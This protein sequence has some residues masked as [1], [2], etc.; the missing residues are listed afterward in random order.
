MKKVVYDS[1]SGICVSGELSASMVKLMGACSIEQLH[2][3]ISKDIPDDPKVERCEII[4]NHGCLEFITDNVQRYNGT[5]RGIRVVPE[6]ATFAGFEF[7][8][9]KVRANPWLWTS[10]NGEHTLD[11]SVSGSEWTPTHAKYVLFNIKT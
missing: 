1:D 7:A 3:T 11:Y 6:M 4:E 5:A 8:D 9:G 2:V 10:P